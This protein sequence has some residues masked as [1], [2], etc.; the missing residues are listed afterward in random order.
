L[1]I[2]AVQL[3]VSEL[4]VTLAVVIVPLPPGTGGVVSATFTATVL[5]LGVMVKPAGLVMPTVTFAPLA[6]EIFDIASV[7]VVPDPV[8]APLV[9]PV[10]VMLLAAIVD[11]FTLKVKVS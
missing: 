5:S 3:S 4:L 8:K 6:T 7:R 2:A 11:G 1:S 10:T 9:A